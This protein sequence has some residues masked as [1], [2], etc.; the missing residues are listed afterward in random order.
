MAWKSAALASIAD[1][2]RTAIQPEHIVA[3]T[4]YVGLEHIV[5]GGELLPP[6]PVRNGE[7]ASTKFRF[8]Q[9]HILYGKLRPYLAK[10]ARPDFSGICSTDILPI[11][12]GKDLER[13]FLLH[14]LRQPAMVQRASNEAVGANLPRLSPSTLARFMVPL[15]PLAEQRRIADILDK[16]DA[17]RAQRRAALA[18]LDTLTQSTFLDLFGDPATNPKNWQVRPLGSIA[19]KKPNN[20][21]FRKNPEYLQNSD[22]GLPVVWVEELFRGDSIDVRASRRLV[23]TPTDVE[24]YGLKNGDILFCRSSLKLDGIAYNNVFVGDD[25]AALFECH[26]IRISPNPKVIDSI[27]LNALFRLPQMRAIAKSRSKTATMTTIDQESLGAIPIVLPPLSK[28]LEFARRITAIE[29]L[30]SRHRAALA[31]L[32]TLFAS[33]QHRAFRGEL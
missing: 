23:A 15:P 3:G 22:L 21:I 5:S 10:I 31:E 14:F 28:Q 18:E 1:I 16:A 29:S 33:L 26:V 13:R 7:L 20:G 25:D 4:L 12:P 11:L 6:Q 8:T 24:K 19:R 32:D 9:K 27:Y 2:D 17:L 30:K